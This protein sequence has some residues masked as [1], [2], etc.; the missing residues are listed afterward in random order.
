[1]NPFQTPLEITING[2][3][4]AVSAPTVGALLAELE[5][6]SVRVAVMRNEKIVPRAARADEPLLPGDIVEIISMVGGG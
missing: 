4:R 1:M 6:E 5:L 2:E 3:K